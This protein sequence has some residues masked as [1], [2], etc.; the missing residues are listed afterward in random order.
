MMTLLELEAKLQTTTGTDIAEVVL[1]SDI[2]FTIEREKQYPFILWMLDGSEFDKDYR[3]STIQETK[4]ITIPV[5]AII[6]YD[7]NADNKLEVWDTLEGYFKTYI[8][9]VNEMTGLQVLNIAELKGTYI[10]DGERSPDRELG[11]MFSKVTLKLF[12]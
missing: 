5:F 6:D 11:I 9:K 7:I 12:C 4:I 8:N 2:Y 3:N 10:W 1:D